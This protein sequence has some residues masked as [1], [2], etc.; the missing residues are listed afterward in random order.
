MWSCRLG[1]SRRVARD[2]A[3]PLHGQCAADGAA[4]A[5]VA[6]AQPPRGPA[7]GAQEQFRL[8]RPAESSEATRGAGPGRRA[9]GPGRG[10]ARE[11]EHVDVFIGRAPPG[12][13]PLVSSGRARSHART[14]GGGGG[15]GLRRG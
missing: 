8:R 6:T 7:P 12:A 13:L 1:S 10:D 3:R 2:P 14:L 11:A 5:G 9:R 15:A 4:G